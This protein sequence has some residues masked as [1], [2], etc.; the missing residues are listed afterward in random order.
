MRG[1]ACCI[2]GLLLVCCI[3]LVLDDGRGRVGLSFTF[4]SA[5]IAVFGE[6]VLEVVVAE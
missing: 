5:R 2:S 6:E 1:F 4:E 3:F